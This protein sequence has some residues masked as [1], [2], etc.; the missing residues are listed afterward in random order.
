[1]VKYR[2]TIL[3]YLLDVHYKKSCLDGYRIV[4]KEMKR[5]KI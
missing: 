1:M 2:I 4:V 3:K 5:E